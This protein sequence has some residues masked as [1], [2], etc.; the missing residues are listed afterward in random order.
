M[1]AMFSTF[2]DMVDEITH[3]LG[4]LD[5]FFH[6]YPEEKEAFY[7]WASENFEMYVDVTMG[8]SHVDWVAAFYDW[9]TE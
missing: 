7:D 5:E 2:D 6:M 1:D 8:K 3:D 4:N 9:L